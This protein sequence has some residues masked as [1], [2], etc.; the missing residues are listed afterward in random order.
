MYGANKAYYTDQYAVTPIIFPIKK[1]YYWSF[2]AHEDLT[3]WKAFW[4]PLESNP[5]PSN[6]SDSENMLAEIQEQINALDSIT[7]LFDYKFE[8][9]NRPLQESLDLGVPFQDLYSIGYRKDDFFGL[10]YQGGIIFYIDDTGEHGL[11]ASSNI[12]GLYEWGCHGINVNGGEGSEIGSGYQNTMD[13]INEGCQ[14]SDGGITA[15]QATLNFNNGLGSDNGG[16][17]DWCIP[18][19]ESLRTLFPLYTASHPFNLQD[20]HIWSSTEQPDHSAFVVYTGNGNHYGSQK[21]T[22]YRI[23]VVRSF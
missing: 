17:S 18:S 4:I 10:I 2:E 14:T 1:N 21:N 5:P 6:D 16:Y 22:N 15:A 7:T 11:V 13:I 20:Q 19:I 23:C 3:V 12:E 9:M 8:L